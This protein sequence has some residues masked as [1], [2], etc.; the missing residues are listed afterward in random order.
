MNAGSLEIVFAMYEQAISRYE[1]DFD[2]EMHGGSIS[3]I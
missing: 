3:K 2:I 1:L